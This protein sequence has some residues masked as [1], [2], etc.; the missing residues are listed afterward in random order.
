MSVRWCDW[1]GEPKSVTAP[2][3]SVVSVSEFSVKATVKDVLLKIQRVFWLERFIDMSENGKRFWVLILNN[4]KTC[5][6][7]F[8]KLMF[9]NIS[10]HSEGISKARFMI[11]LLLQGW[12][13]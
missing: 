1:K 10:S 12:F 5:I 8:T 2:M 4:R 3:P 9:W 6:I 7:S 11:L 13:P